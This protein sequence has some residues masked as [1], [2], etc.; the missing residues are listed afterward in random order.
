M[1]PKGKLPDA[2]IADLAKWVDMGAPD[3]RDGSVLPAKRIIDL[4]S[5]KKNWA[6]RALTPVRPPEVKN[7]SWTRTPIDRFILARLESKGLAPARPLDRGQL[8]RRVSF[9]LLGLPPTPEE[10]DAFVKDASPDAYEK[11]IDRLLQSERYG[12]RWARHW[13]DL[14]RFAESGGYEFDGDR[15]GAYQFRDFVIKALNDGMPYDEFVRLQLA[16]D[17]LKPDD[18]TAAAATGFLVAGPYPGQ[19]TAKTLEPIRYDHLDD[20]ISTVG[21]GLLGLSLGCARCHEHKYDPIPQQDY[22]HLLA[23]LARTDSMTQYK[24]DPN[25]EVYRRAKSV[26]DKAHAPLLAARAKFE[27]DEL[28]GRLTKWLAAEKAKPVCP[29]LADPRSGHSPRTE[30]LQEN[31]GRL[32]RPRPDGHHYRCRP[33]LP[34]GYHQPPAGSP[35]RPRAAEVGPGSGRRRQFPP[36]RREPDCRAAAGRVKKGEAPVVV[37]LKP[38]GATFEQPGHPLGGKAGWSIGGATGKPHAGRLRGGNARSASRAGRSS[39]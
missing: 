19:T 12:E 37:K 13:L 39:R 38:A 32:A 1:P 27:K 33:H 23:N 30:P 10:I 24:L 2:V 35:P 26:F 36:D 3:P 9:D 11:L 15:P 20:M 34:E 18:L 6:F 25:P 31:G 5:S 4:D 22:Y 21:T 29:G 7:A 17:H 8:I 28:P 16:G 14:A